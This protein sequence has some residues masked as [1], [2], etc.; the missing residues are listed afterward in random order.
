MARNTPR[1]RS[2]GQIAAYRIVDKLTQGSTHHVGWQPGNTADTERAEAQSVPAE[3]AVAPEPLDTPETDPN[4]GPGPRARDEFFNYDELYSRLPI[5]PF[6]AENKLLNNRYPT[7]IGDLREG[8]FL[9][10]RHDCLQ[11]NKPTIVFYTQ[12]PLRHT[13]GH[14]VG[15]PVPFEH[16]ENLVI[17]PIIEVMQ[18]C[19]KAR[20]DTNGQPYPGCSNR[21]G[22]IT[23]RIKHPHTGKIVFVYPYC[24]ADKLGN[25]NKAAHFVA[26]HL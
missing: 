6:V 24:Y 23:C 7:N 26:T 20:L 21:Q 2:P 18:T 14:E 12:P 5:V 8:D 17:G 13:Y 3:V 25:T 4:L 15:Q 11:P 22:F 9:I 16:C 10:S 19:Q 1:T